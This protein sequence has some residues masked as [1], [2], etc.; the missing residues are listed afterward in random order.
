MDFI[1]SWFNE[2]SKQRFFRQQTRAM[3]TAIEGRDVAAIK[4][5]WKQIDDKEGF[6]GSVTDDGRGFLD[7][8]VFKGGG[9]HSTH[10]F[11]RLIVSA[12]DTDNLDVFKAV[13]EQDP[14][15]NYVISRWSYGDFAN[16]EESHDPVLS[17]AIKQGKKNIALYL[18]AR[19]E[20]GRDIVGYKWSRGFQRSDN[21][22]E[23]DPV[24]LELARTNPGMKDVF[25]EMVKMGYP[26]SSA[27][28][29][30]AQAQNPRTMFPQA[31]RL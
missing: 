20:T 18:A 23:L 1:Q 7:A 24:P 8:I 31:F 15:P 17:L 22:N 11:S 28:A 16:V 21:K 30:P 25:Y 14:N 29:K 3:L 5:I 6:M 2:L 27:G 9:T 12:M 13:F 19:P 26:R 4:A 10:V